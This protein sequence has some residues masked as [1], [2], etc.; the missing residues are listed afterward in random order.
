MIRMTSKQLAAMSDH[1]HK[2]FSEP[3]GSRYWAVRARF[4]YDR[5]VAKPEDF[6]REEDA[7]AKWT[8]ADAEDDPRAVYE[9]DV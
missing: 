8:R 2:L 3:D 9:L 4:T 5:C 6:G 1:G 7:E